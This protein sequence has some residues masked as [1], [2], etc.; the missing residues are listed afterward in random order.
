MG[1]GAVYVC[2]CE[3]A[4][5]CGCVGEGEGVEWSGVGGVAYDWTAYDW[6]ADASG[7]DALCGLAN[8]H[9]FDLGV[10]GQGVSWGSKFMC[11]IFITCGRDGKTTAR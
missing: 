7:M 4:I 8:G 1:V 6:T 11:A 3:W 9:P 10:C 2:E 5:G